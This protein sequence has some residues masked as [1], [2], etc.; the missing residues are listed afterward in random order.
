MPFPPDAPTRI[1]EKL[2]QG[3]L[4]EKYSE[5]MWAG[6]GNG[7][8]CDGCDRPVLSD[9]VEYE[10]EIDGGRTL[11]FHLG[12]AALWE[13]YRGRGTVR[14]TDNTVTNETGNGATAPAA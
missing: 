3:L 11:R 5:K 2:S 10:F 8:P 7:R 6:R 12:C 1:R 13:A 14:G 9:Q 4:P